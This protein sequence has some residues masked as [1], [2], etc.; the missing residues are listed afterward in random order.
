M[1]YKELA[2]GKWDGE[3]TSI[4]FQEEELCCIGQFSKGA[5]YMYWAGCWCT[6]WQ[7]VWLSC[8]VVWK[9]WVLSCQRGQ[10]YPHQY[11]AAMYSCVSWTFCLV[12]CCSCLRFS[13]LYSCVTFI[14]LFHFFIAEFYEEALSLV[15]DLTSKTISPDM[16]K[17]L[18]LIYQVSV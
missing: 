4:Y 2:T 17:V 3:G 10:F 13:L 14:V 9:R 7:S 18:E 16:W 1:P 11:R 12:R 5:S 6:G 15:Y 8:I